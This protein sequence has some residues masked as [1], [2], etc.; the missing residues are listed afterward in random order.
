MSHYGIGEKEM[1]FAEMIWELGPVRSGEL[2][3]ICEK[4]FGWKKSTMYTVLSKLCAR[5]L[6]QNKKC[7]VTPLLT[8][9][10]F[11]SKI[12]REF[13]TGEFGGSLPQFVLAFTGKQ[14]LTKKEKEELLKVVESLKDR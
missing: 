11:Q 2:A 6:F 12:S 1:R 5:G 9:E 10:E 14:G 4:E 3:E 8:K 7:V 13:V